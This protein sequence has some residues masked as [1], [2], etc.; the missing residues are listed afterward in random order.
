L[1]RILTVGNAPGVAGEAGGLGPSP[2]DC[3][4]LTLTRLEREEVVRSDMAGL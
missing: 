1:R 4:I 2:S 3:R